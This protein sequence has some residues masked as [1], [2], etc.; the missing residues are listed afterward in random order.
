MLDRSDILWFKTNFQQP[1]AKTIAGTQLTLDFVAALA[2]QETGEVWPALRRKG[3]SNDRV[4]A[5]CV[6]DTLDADKGRSAF[7]KTKSDLVAAP[8]GDEMFAIARQALVEM[9]QHI[10]AYQPAANRPNKFCHGVG[11]FQLD[12]FRWLAAFGLQ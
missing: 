9:A 8:R 11:L 1:I 2:C 7:P 4:L 10:P 6:G 12:L 3:M 5:M